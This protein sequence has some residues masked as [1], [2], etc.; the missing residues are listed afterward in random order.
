MPTKVEKALVTGTA[1]TGHGWDGIKELDTP[2]PKWWLYVCYATIAWSIGYFVFFPAWP[3][4]SSHTA[5]VLGYWSRAEI[6][7]E[8]AAQVAQRAPFVERIR[9]EPLDRIESQP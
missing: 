2:L 3:S 4:L 6:R 9:K 1:T 7:D 5:G 8:L